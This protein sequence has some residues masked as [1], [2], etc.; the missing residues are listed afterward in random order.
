MFYIEMR[1]QNPGIVSM[2][3]VSNQTTRLIN[4]Q[5]VA[6]ST[7][8]SPDDQFLAYMQNDREKGITEIKILDL[9]NNQTRTLT[10]AESGIL[11]NPLVWSADG[12]RLLVGVNMGSE[13]KGLWSVSVADPAN[14]A[15][16][17]LQEAHNS[18]VVVSPNGQHIA[19]QGGTRRAE[20]F[21][22]KTE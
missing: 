7:C 2:D 1:F 12:K 5:V 16:I 15:F 19:Y 14:V 10:A 21:Y 18:T 13:K 11:S 3:P 22:L 20:M 8:I 6:G 4:G 9:S 17:P